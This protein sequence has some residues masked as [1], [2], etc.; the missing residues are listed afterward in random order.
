MVVGGAT[1]ELARK[2]SIQLLLP[3]DVLTINARRDL[4]R[5]LESDS[6]RLSTRTA[7]APCEH[8][9]NLD[10]VQLLQANTHCGGNWAVD[11]PNVALV[12]NRTIG[13]CQAL[14]V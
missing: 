5:Q 4:Q 6:K 13:V 1:F 8:G 9:A 12:N 10:V 14:C 7:A 11:V 3:Y 2:K